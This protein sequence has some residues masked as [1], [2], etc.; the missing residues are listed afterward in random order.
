MGRSLF[1]S[2]GSIARVS[3]HSNLVTV[4]RV[5]F[6]FPFTDPILCLFFFFFF[7]PGSPGTHDWYRKNLFAKQTWGFWLPLSSVQCQVHSHTVMY[8]SKPSADVLYRKIP[9][10]GLVRVFLEVYCW[11]MEVHTGGPALTYPSN[12]GSSRTLSQKDP[13]TSTEKNY[14][15]QNTQNYH[16]PP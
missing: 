14:S 9:S 16:S 15:P 11:K 4:S 5:F 12:K 8:L 2:R 3:F 6:S 13:H 10:S 1:S 7:F